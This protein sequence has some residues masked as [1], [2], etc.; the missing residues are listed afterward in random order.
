MYKQKGILFDA[1]LCIGCGACYEACKQKNKLPKTNKNFLSDHLSADTYSV[2]EQYGDVYARKLCMHC[3]EP[4]CVSVCPVG[5]F[6][7]SETGSVIYDGNKC[8]GCRYCMQAC[9]HK[10]PRYKW[11]TTKPVVCKCNMCDERI[12]IGKIPACAEACPTE[13]TLFGDLDEIIQ[14]AKKRIKENKRNYYPHIYGLEEAGG[15]HVLILSPVPFEQLGYTPHLPKDP[16]PM[17]TMR[18]TEKIPPIV[19]VGGLFL[20]GMFWLTKRK[21]QIAKEES[22]KKKEL[23]NHE[24]R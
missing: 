12:K 14:V 3:D 17:L 19:G 13:A 22:A 1:T 6:S 10:V 18:A 5:A 4:A 9:P 24:S 8:I 21:N 15:S 20:G 11:E 2:V 7:K 16:M 23:Q